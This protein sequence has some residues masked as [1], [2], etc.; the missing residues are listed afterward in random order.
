MM[1]ISVAVLLP[2]LA[3]AA[4][5]AG[6]GGVFCGR[7][8][9]RRRPTANT[10]VGDDAERL[11]DIIDLAADWVWET[12]SDH[13]YTYVSPRLIEHTG[14]PLEHWLNSTRFDTLAKAH[15]REAVEPHIQDITAHRPFRDLE[16][17]ID[18]PTGLHCFQT[19]GKPKFDA[20]GKFLGYRGTGRDI[21]ARKKAEADLEKAHEELLRQERLVTLGQLT[22][23]VSHELRNPLGAI[24]TSA[25][26]VRQKLAD[27]DP[28][29]GAA[30]E[31]IVRNVVRCD[32]IID[33]LLDFG[34]FRGAE[35]E[36][37]TVEAWL[38]GVLDS[39]PVAESVT[40]V[41]DFE[42][43][44]AI[45]S[46][47]REALHRVVVNLYDN[48]CHAMVSMEGADAC[49]QRVLTVGARRVGDSLEI[50]F[51]DTGVGVP[52][53]ILPRL[54]EPMFSTKAFGV[55]LGLPVVR[56]IA[57]QHG[58]SVDISNNED[59]GGAARLTLP[60]HRD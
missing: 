60:L 45:C 25:Y 12:D 21:T 56:K 49:A 34:G 52:E 54:F 10:I 16:Y 11:A 55:G 3:G 50:E 2:L 47:D 29:L 4:A 15:D 57:E 23:T 46:I 42:A 37:T 13:R 24:R 44:G 5:L 19:S 30:I 58:G 43:G 8:L 33:E 27:S 41:R 53:D 59:G 51:R 48:A 9:A 14:L 28:Q 40:V 1:R 20:D 18:R 35:L 39:Q 26:V 32:R 38:G 17:W 6:I 31:R 22:A 36:P 7:W